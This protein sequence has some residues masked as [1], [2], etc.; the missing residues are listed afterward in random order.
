MTLLRYIFPPPTKR[1]NRLWSS[2]ISRAFFDNFYVNKDWFIIR[3]YYLNKEKAFEH[4]Y[5]KIL[6][7]GQSFLLFYI[8]LIGILTTCSFDW[9]MLKPASFKT[10][11]VQTGSTAA[12]HVGAAPF[13]HVA[14]SSRSDLNSVRFKWNGLKYYLLWDHDRV[15]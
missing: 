8:I 7:F 5:P 1:R 10:N 2:I 3:D 13:A 9:L 6:L 14:R 4:F 15:T 11:S 12:S